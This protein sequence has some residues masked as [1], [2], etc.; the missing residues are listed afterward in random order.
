MIRFIY[1]ESGFGKTRTIIDMLKADAERGTRSFLIVPEQMAVSGERMLLDSLPTSAQLSCEVLNFSRLYNRVCREYGGLEYNYITAPA[2]HLLMWRTLHELAPI[3]EH[4]ELSGGK[5]ISALELMLGAAQEFKANAILPHDLERA[6]EKLSNQSP[7]SPKLRDISLIYSAYCA[8]ISESFSD[9]ADDISKLADTLRAHNFFAN[10]NVYIDS[11]TSFTAA[12]HKV[13]ERI[14]AQA[15]NV[16]VTIPL[17]SPRYESIYTASISASERRLI[18]SAEARGGYTADILSENKRARSPELSHL[19]K[20]LWELGVT[21]ASEQTPSSNIPPVVFEQCSTPYAEA[22][23]AAR[24]CLE[25]MRHGVRCRDIAVIMRDAEKYRGIIEPAMEDCNI[26]F[27]F[28]EKSDLC[29]KSPVK[30]ILSALKIKQYGWRRADVI[31]HL[32]TGFYDISL[33]SADM[34]ESYVNTWNIK[35]GRFL[36]EYWTMNPDGYAREISERGQK[37]LTEANN[38][39]GTLCDSLIPLFA[40]LDAAE[41]AAE[42]CRAIYEYIKECDLETKLTQLAKRAA[43]AGEQ[44]QSQEYLALYRI[45][46]DALATV[47][48]LL[49]DTEITVLELESALSIVFNMTEIGT[50]P[51]SVDEVTVG[52][53]SMLRVENPRCVIV[54]GL[55]EGE[56]PQGISDTG[57]LSSSERDALGELGIEFSAN[58]EVRSSDEL[59]FVKRSFSLPSEHLILTTSL[60]ESDGRTRQPSLAYIRAKKLLPHI[61]EHRFEEWDL[62]YLT[63]TPEVAAKYLRTQRDVSAEMSIRS[64]LL[65]LGE[66]FEYLRAPSPIN[67]SVSDCKVSKEVVEEI[68]PNKMKLSQSRLEK[69]IKCNFSYYCSYVLGLREESKADFKASEI[70]TFVHFILETLISSISGKDG[71]SSEIDDGQLVKM[72]D[73]AVRRYVQYICPAYERA[74][75]RFVHLYQ[76][77]RNLSLLLIKNIISEFSASDFVPSYFELK[78]GRGENSLP[79]LEFILKDGSRVSLSGVIDRVDILRRDGKVYVRVVDYKTG[80]KDFS[81]DDLKLGLNTQMLIYLFTL[82]AR[83]SPALFGSDSAPLPAG[84]VYLSSNIPTVELEDYTSDSEILSMAEGAL[85]R[86]GLLI[87]D[88]EIL[89]AMNKDLSPYFLA[90]VKHNKSGE[91]SGSALISAE[92]FDTLRTEIEEVITS[93]ASKMREGVANADPMTVGRTSPCDYCEMKPVCRRECK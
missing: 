55:C 19:A 41:G 76:R 34:F 77:L 9:S 26:P 63:P 64:A 15:E 14:F 36:D 68:F 49:T 2:K 70:G 52:S 83:P 91:L 6:C 46:L 75:G 12:E 38:V 65:S 40:K 16:T 72:T 88:E 48:E 51:T 3:L 53:A 35:G 8:L 22:E 89:K 17:P 56:F 18:K 86:R 1:G 74:T 47:A 7:L 20:H 50:I 90:G 61:T 69:Y 87:W 59:L 31:S 28:S 44:K 71:I 54:L 43:D 30:F 4:Y 11:F 5:E 29:S 85:D 25:F 73:E 62:S 79:P 13:I 33:A 45:I 82:C 42:M 66:D 92:G 10:C 60:F 80:T 27:F 21:P 23:A 39:R 84:M 81:L 32:K 93:I 37:I 57:L 58:R 78:I 67:L 24:W